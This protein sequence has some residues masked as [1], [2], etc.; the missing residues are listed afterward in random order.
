MTIVVGTIQAGQSLSD[1]IDCSAGTIEHIAMPA[2][3]TGALLSFQAS[4]DNT[5]YYDMFRSDNTE[6]TINITP[7]TVIALS[8]DLFPVTAKTW[9]KIR[10]GSRNYPVAQ[11]AQRQFRLEIA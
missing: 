5:T 2:A 10:S 3:W 7:N 6:I 4:G 8:P 9:L 1:P 11:Q